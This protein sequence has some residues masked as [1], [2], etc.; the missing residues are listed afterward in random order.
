MAYATLADVRAYLGL[1]T[2]E[3]GDDTL[4]TAFITRA[5]KIIESYCRRTFEASIDTTRTFDPTRQASGRLLYLDHDLAAITTVTN[6]DGVA[7]T[8][9][10]TLPAN[11]TPYY[12]LRIKS[13]AGQTWTYSGDPE[14]AIS[15]TGRWA[16]STTAPADIA[17][18]TIRLAAYIYKQKDNSLDLDRT[19]IAGDA[20]ILPVSLP[21][22]LK[23]L[24]RS[25]RRLV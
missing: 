8:E 23:L 1:A 3:T 7:V 12:G 22:D 13:N 2:A 16:Y 24:L 18:A 11:E 25:Y 4:I 15:I 19:V 21:S 20:T 6:G 5:Q 17:H 14:G 9:Y 10:A